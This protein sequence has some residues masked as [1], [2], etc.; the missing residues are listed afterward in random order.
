MNNA[1]AMFVQII[2]AAAMSMQIKRAAALSMLK[3]VI[4]PCAYARITRATESCSGQMLCP[5][6][7]YL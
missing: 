5:N 6:T 7:A 2:Y 1:A 3:Y 4:R